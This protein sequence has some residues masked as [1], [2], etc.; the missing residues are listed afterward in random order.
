MMA[1]PATTI[2]ELLR[3]LVAKS[4][5]TEDEAADVLLRSAAHFRTAADGPH[6]AVAYGVAHAF[7]TYATFFPTKFQ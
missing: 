6:A 1:A 2:F 4:I 7:D 5:L 3:L